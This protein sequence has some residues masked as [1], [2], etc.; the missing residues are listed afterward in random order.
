VQW[1][2]RESKRSTQGGAKSHRSARIV[3]LASPRSRALEIRVGGG[4]PR[5]ELQ[6]TEMGPT[7]EMNEL[8]ENCIDGVVKFS[9]RMVQQLNPAIRAALDV[10]I[11]AGARVQVTV[12]LTP[13]PGIRGTVEVGGQSAQLFEIR[14]NGDPA[15][16]VMH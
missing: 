10:A 6:V 2:Q 16:V 12:E 3:P 1:N 14:L 13:S 11:F 8:L 5:M 7:E 15:P 9:N 4:D